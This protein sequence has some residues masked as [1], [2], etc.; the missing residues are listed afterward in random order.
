MRKNIMNRTKRTKHDGF[1]LVELMVVIAIIGIVAVIAVPNFARIQRQ[2]R[3]RSACQRTAQHLKMLRERAISTNNTYQI[4]FRVPDQYH[5]RMVRPDGT[6]EDFRLSG[7]TGGNVYFGGVNVAGQPP[8]ASMAAP[9]N[10]GVDF[11][12]NTLEIYAGYSHPV[13][14]RLPEGI[15][16]EVDKNNRIT[17]KGIDKEKVG[18]TAADIRAI[19]PPE[20]YKGKGILYAGERIRRKAG[21]AG[22]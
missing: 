15:S 22:A 9:G 14:F 21:K 1:T 10:L 20:P 16:A 6:T 13:Q 17:V 5:Y 18:Q 12:G 2:A 8:E 11:P 7:T 4:L 19:R 3:L